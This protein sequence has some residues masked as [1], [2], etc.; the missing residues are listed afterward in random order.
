MNPLN[1]IALVL[2]TRALAV[3]EVRGG[4]TGAGGPI[5]ETIYVEID[6]ARGRG[7]AVA[8]GA[9]TERFYPSFYIVFY[10]NF[11]GSDPAAEKERL[12]RVFWLYR[13]ALYAERT[14]GGRVDDILV[15]EW[16]AD[17]VKR[18]NEYYWYWALTVQCEMEA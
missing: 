4:R 5:P 15:T 3:A 8:A 11:T 14:L 6:D 16:D 18:G 1:D 9:D 17:L 10:D 12:R 2:L 13:M 7:E